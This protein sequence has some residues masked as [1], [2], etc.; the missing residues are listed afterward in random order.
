MAIDPSLINVNFTST[1]GGEIELGIVPSAADC[2]TQQA[3]YYDDPAMPTRIMLCPAAC[4]SVRGDANASIAIL[5]GCKPRIP[6]TKLAERRARRRL[7]ALPS[8]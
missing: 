5:A 8:P 7:L 2:G 1:T 6:V 3:W 4:T